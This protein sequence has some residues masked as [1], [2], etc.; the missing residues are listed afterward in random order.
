MRP[1]NGNNDRAREARI[2]ALGGGKGGVGKSVLGAN[3][4]GQLA[5]RGERVALVDVDLGGANLHTILGIAH[6]RLT[7][8]D[9]FAKRVSSLA[10]V[11]VPAGIPN[12]FLISGSP[13][14][15]ELANLKY[16]QKLKLFRHLRGLEVDVVL[17][18]LGAGTAFNVLDFFLFAHQ[19]MLVIVPEPTSVENAYQFL[20]A[21]LLRKIE[22]A[23]PRQ[24]IK[25]L[26][27]E[28]TSAHS[29]PITSPQEL[30]SQALLAD[31]EIGS[32]LISEVQ[33]FTPSLIVNRVNTIEEHRLGEDIATACLD[34]FGCEIG[35]LGNVA[36]DRVVE[37]SILS[38]TLAIEAYPDSLFADSIRHLTHRLT[39][40]S[41][42]AYG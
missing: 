27:T 41:E 14:P 8:S 13:S 4:A 31:P 29:V 16:V 34:Y 38:R 39:L 3:I 33:S 24:R 2:L 17:L 18:D 11:M 20:R 32:T 7:L 22:Q 12:L 21:A 15:M 1:G 30:V 36:N 42:S 28:I 37:Q 40:R 6:P 25:A 26:I 9:F 19:G 23:E 5:K 10:Q 35:F